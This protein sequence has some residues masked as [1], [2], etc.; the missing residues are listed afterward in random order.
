MITRISATMMDPEALGR[1]QS[2]AGE[3]L[4]ELALQVC[5]EGGV[6][7][8]YVYEVAIAGNATMTALVLGIDP[9]PLG[10]APF[11]QT[12]SQPP[13]VLADEIGLHLHPRA[14]AAFFPALGAYVGGDIVA[15]HAGHRAWTATSAPG[16]SSTSAPTARSCSAT[17]TP[18]SP[19]RPRPVRP[20]R[21]VRS[22]AACAR[23]TVPSR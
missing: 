18:S 20:S 9:E 8:A 4:D 10:V 12:T 1:L 5:T 3:T 11:V 17:A 7:P 21:A 6:D 14:R 2:L 22:A 19:P 13:V 16:C 23:P 15:G